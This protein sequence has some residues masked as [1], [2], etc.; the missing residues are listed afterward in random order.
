V[1]RWRLWLQDVV[2]PPAVL[3]LVLLL[4]W[5][6]AVE[7]GRIKPILLPGPLAVAEAVVR[8]FG[9]LA[10]AAAFSG[11]AAGL[12]FLISLLAGT[13]IAFAFSQSKWLRCSGY[14]YA[15]FVQTVPIV[16]IAP[17][18]VHWCGRGWH[19]VVLTASILGLFP[20]I[21]N[22]TSGLLSVDPDLLD[23]FRLNNASRWQV[24]WKLRFPSAVPALCAGAKT[25]CGLTVVGSIVGEYFVGY[26][27]RSY[28]LGYLILFT[29]DQLRMA[30]LFAAVLASTL[31]AVLMFS[32]VSLATTAILQRWYDAPIEHRR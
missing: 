23:L 32:A 12:G 20:I 13:L 19:S 18:I 9:K 16:A 25:S 7:V 27:S 2:L 1:K 24:L 11:S 17:L 15:L 31:L 21:S 22:G 5:H 14:P 8:N 30:E 3:L 29:T 10:R 26:G 4:V 28:G 6:A